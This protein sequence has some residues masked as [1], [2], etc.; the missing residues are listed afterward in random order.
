M[1]I[2]MFNHNTPNLEA[3]LARAC[4]QLLEGTKLN[5][6]GIQVKRKVM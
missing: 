2:H 5:L 6:V 4:P 3:V 1:R